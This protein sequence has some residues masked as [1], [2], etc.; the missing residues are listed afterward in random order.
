M[1]WERESGDKQ[2]ANGVHQAQDAWAKA[3]AACA[4]HQPA[5]NRRPASI[6]CEQQVDQ[7]GAA[8]IG[9]ADD[10]DLGFS[11]DSSYRLQHEQMAEGKAVDTDDVLSG[12]S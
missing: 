7:W 6:A 11:A 9:G 4:C 2:H 1:A 10:L 12:M 8:R 5:A 3:T